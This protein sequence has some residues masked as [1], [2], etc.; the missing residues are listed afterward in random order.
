MKILIAALIIP[1]ELV[2]QPTIGGVSVDALSH[3]DFRMTWTASGCFQTAQR[4]RFGFT[5]A[6]EG[7]AGGGILGGAGPGNTPSGTMTQFGLS[8]LLPDTNYHVC[9]QSSCD[10]GAT[11]SSCS[12]VDQLV[13]TLPLPS[14]HPAK[15]VPPPAYMP[16]FPNTAGYHTVTISSACAGAARE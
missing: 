14:V 1:L 8:G 12:A 2:A 4:I 10:N 6:Y 13:T 16:T 9:P 7:G 11:W 3:S 15:P 5:T